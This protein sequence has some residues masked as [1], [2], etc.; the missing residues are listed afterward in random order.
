MIKARSEAP[1]AG[2]DFQHLHAKA[3][4]K[5]TELKGPQLDSNQGS[6]DDLLSSLGL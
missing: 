2:A 6:V 4:D 3:K 1:D 5:L